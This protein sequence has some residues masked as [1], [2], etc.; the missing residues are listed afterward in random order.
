MLSVVYA[1]CHAKCRYGECH[2]A[3]CRGAVWKGLLLILT[4]S[5]IYSKKASSLVEQVLLTFEKKMI[6]IQSDF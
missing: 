1:A 6:L 5:K 2:Y 4:F 3:E